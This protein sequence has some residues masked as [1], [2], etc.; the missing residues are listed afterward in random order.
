MFCVASHDGLGVAC[1]RDLCHFSAVATGVEDPAMS[2]NFAVLISTP[3]LYLQRSLL[4]KLAQTFTSCILAVSGL[5][6][7]YPE[8]FRGFFSAPPRNVLGY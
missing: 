2:A 3:K 4:R 7:Y 8:G 6:L 1:R 5:D